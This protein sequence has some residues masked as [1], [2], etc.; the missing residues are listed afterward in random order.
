MVYLEF[1]AKAS[2]IPEIRLLAGARKHTLRAATVQ[3]GDQIRWSV[4]VDRFQNVGP[5]AN[6]ARRRLTDP[7]ILGPGAPPSPPGPWTSQDFQ[8]R[9]GTREGGADRIKM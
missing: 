1:G 5:C 6:G 8:G 9:Y 2:Q 4:A 7:W 3:L